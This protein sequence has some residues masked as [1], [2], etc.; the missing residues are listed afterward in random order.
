MRQRVAARCSAMQGGA[1]CCSMLQCVAAIFHQHFAVT[2]FQ[3][4]SLSFF[5]SLPL[6]SSLLFPL[7]S[8]LFIYFCLVTYHCNTLHHTTTHCQ[9]LQDTA[10]HCNTLQQPGNCNTLQQSKNNLEGRLSKVFVKFVLHRHS[11]TARH[12]NTLQHT[13]RNCN[14]L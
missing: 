1:L 12:C 8:S 2:D 10:T 9:T 6:S 3:V 7:S 14:T 4:S 5:L 11:D 13:A